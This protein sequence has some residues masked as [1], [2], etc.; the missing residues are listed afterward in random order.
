MG[1]DTNAPVPSCPDLEQLM[2][3][4]QQGDTTAVTALVEC[5][6]PRLYGL[7]ASLT[8]SSADAEEMLQEAWLRIHRV[9]HTY[10]GSEPVLPWLYAIARSVQVKRSSKAALARMAQGGSWYLSGFFH[11]GR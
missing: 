2:K 9:R 3:P 5:L 8:N 4:Y 11:T 6:T 7:F 1:S 10:R